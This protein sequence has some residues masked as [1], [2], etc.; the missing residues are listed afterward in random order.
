MNKKTI[1][2]ALPAYAAGHAALVV[3]ALVAPLYGGASLAIATFGRTRS[4]IQPRSA[5]YDVPK[6]TRMLVEHPAVQESLAAIAE[7]APEPI[8]HGFRADIGGTHMSDEQALR[9]TTRT[10]LHDMADASGVSIYEDVA[11]SPDLPGWFQLSGG[12]RG[13]RYHDLVR[14]CDQFVAATE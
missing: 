9:S 11:T 1:C 12:R 10:T 6:G 4:P 13:R 3:A 8:D 14:V 2:E 7:P 5:Q